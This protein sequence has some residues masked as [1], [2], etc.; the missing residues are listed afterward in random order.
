MKLVVGFGNPGS[1][2]NFTRH[3]FG[4]LALDF[5]AKKQGWEWQ[6][7]PKFNAVWAKVGDIIYI[8][9]QTFY[10]EVGRCVQYFMHYYKIDAT[11]LLIICDDFDMDF[12]KIRFRKKGSHGGNNG[13]RS[14][15]KELGTTEF[16]RLKLGTNNKELRAKMKNDTDFVLGRFTPE[17]KEQLPGILTE[18]SNRLVGLFTA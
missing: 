2:Y 9:P 17:E 11:D 16:A 1:Q 14:V 4:F 6:K 7:Q 8:K 3:N 12:G 13:L 5:L 10:N 18:I 15:I